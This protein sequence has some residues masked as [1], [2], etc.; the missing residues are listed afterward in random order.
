MPSAEQI[1]GIQ[2]TNL[3]W[4][5]EPFLEEW[6]YVAASM[7]KKKPRENYRYKEVSNDA[8]Q[9]PNGPACRGEEQTNAPAR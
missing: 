8:Q 6:E 7:K 3:M 9:T 4:T 5:L 2:S 1:L